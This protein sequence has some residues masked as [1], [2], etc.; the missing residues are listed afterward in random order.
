LRQIRQFSRFAGSYQERKIVQSRVARH[1]VERTSRRGGRILD[2]GAGSG[3]IYRLLPWKA[4]RFYA[5]DASEEMLA[6]HPPCDKK[7]LCDFDHESCWRELETLGIDQVFAA[8]SLQW[9]RD[10]EGVLGRIAAL[11]PHVSLAIFTASTFRTI[12][13]MA[14]IPSP[15]PEKRR[16]IEAIR[17]HFR[18]TIEVRE[19]K[20][21]FSDPLEMFRYI[22]RSGV[23]S[24]ER[25]LGYKELK[26]LI[27]AYPLPYLEFEVVFAWS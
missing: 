19:Y 23:S 17:S 14:S 25:K 5:V 27:R 16:I 21:F 11:T 12:H 8:S 4:E 9:S 26:R 10:L 1:L 13:A 3:E 15:I 20:L 6:L 24:G 18:A 7:I 2:L 22:K